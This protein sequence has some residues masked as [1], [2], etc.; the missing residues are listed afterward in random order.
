VASVG[1]LLSKPCHFAHY[2]P[3]GEKIDRGRKKNVETALGDQMMRKNVYQR[4]DQKLKKKSRKSD[5]SILLAII[6]GHERGKGKER[7]SLN[8]KKPG[9]VEKMSGSGSP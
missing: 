3:R 6:G 7:G 8:K 9:N 4:T 2:R 5:P 1:R